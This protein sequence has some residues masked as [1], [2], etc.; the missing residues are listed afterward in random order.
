MHSKQCR[1]VCRNSR[2]MFTTHIEAIVSWWSWK[3]SSR[4]PKIEYS[5]SADPRPRRIT[6][7]LCPSMQEGVLWNLPGRVK[8]KTHCAFSIR[9][10]TTNKHSYAS[11]GDF[12]HLCHVQSIWTLCIKNYL[13]YT[14]LCWE[15][16]LWQTRIVAVIFCTWCYAEDNRAPRGQLPP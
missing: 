9:E 12:G 16:G 11:E 10:N 3:R 4:A 14:A 2:D 13:P 7:V 8:P 15:L 6:A 1:K 5:F